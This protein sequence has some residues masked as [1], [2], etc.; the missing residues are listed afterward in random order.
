MD[1]RNIRQNVFRF[2]AQS[3]SSVK[4]DDCIALII[5]EILGY[6]NRKNADNY[7]PWADIC[8]SVKNYNALNKNGLVEKLK[9][10]ILK[11]FTLEKKYELLETKAIYSFNIDYI[12]F[13]EKFIEIAKDQTY[14]LR[15]NYGEKDYSTATLNITS[16]PSKTNIDAAKT[17]TKENY[18][19][20]NEEVKLN[21]LWKTLETEERKKL[22]PFWKWK[23][24]TAE[25]KSLEEY[26]IALIKRKGHKKVIVN[27]AI[28][29]ALFY[30]EWYKIKYTG[31]DSI[32]DTSFESISAQS[33]WKHLSADIRKKYLITINESKINE[34][35][36]WDDSLKLLGGL[37]LSYL[38]KGENNPSRVFARVFNN[39]RIEKEL[40]LNELDLNNQAMRQ[41]AQ[42]GG[43]IYEYIN[44]LINENYPFAE[45]DK[46]ESPFKEF[47]AFVGTG[48]K[49]FKEN[50]SKKFSIIWQVRQHTDFVNIY[51]AI[52]VKLKPEQGGEEHLFIH[53]ERLNE[54][55]IQ[56][57]LSSFEIVIRLKF[58]DTDELIEKGGF[59]F[60]RC[61]NGKFLCRSALKWQICDN[62]KNLE[63]I[64]FVLKSDEFEKAIQREKIPNYI[65]LWNSSYGEWTNRL[66]NGERSSVLFLNNNVSTKNVDQQLLLKS[67]EQDY[68]W[69]VVNRELEI[70]NNGKPH[71]LYQKNGTIEV[72]P[73]N[74]DLFKNTIRYN[75]DGLLSYLEGEITSLVY[76]VK[77]PVTFDVS[78]IDSNGSNKVLINSKDYSVH[79]KKRDM[80][81]FKHYSTG[82]SLMQGFVSFK[83][84]YKDIYKETIDCYLLELKADINRVLETKKISFQKIN[85][86]VLPKNEFVDDENHLENDTIKIK[87][88][89]ED[90]YLEIPIIRPLDRQNDIFQDRKYIN[91]SDIIPIKFAD[92]FVVRSI[93]S[94]GVTRKVLSNEIDKFQKLRVTYNNNHGKN[95]QTGI[96]G[97]PEWIKLTTYTKE[98][99][100]NGDFYF[101]TKGKNIS[102]E[103]FNGYKFCFLSLI[104]LKVEDLELVYLKK[105]SHNYVGFSISKKVDGIV[106][107]SFKDESI[108]YQETYRPVF[109]AADQSKI[110]IRTKQENRENRIK[111]YKQSFD[112][113]L[114]LNHFELAIVHN[115]Y[116]GMF[117]ILLA[118]EDQPQIL[119]KFHLEYYQHC[120]VQKQSVNYTALHRFAEEMLFDW[121][122]IPR[123]IWTEVIKNEEGK[124]DWVIN[125]FKNKKTSSGVEQYALSQCCEIY[126][127]SKL[128][129]TNQKNKI[130]MNIKRVKYINCF[131][132][133]KPEEKIK[134]LKKLDETERLY[135]DLL[136]ILKK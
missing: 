129:S 97:M 79:F 60:N 32:I 33:I 23:I 49:E 93:N 136:E 103:S 17:T 119:A 38:I 2:L 65:Q 66:I 7:K 15:T 115:L 70:L 90:N 82:T 62:P 120:T 110:N 30:S 81:G 96:K 88:G 74:K 43:S 132:I 114:A 51:P 78:Y 25:F 11:N 63:S 19:F 12:I 121:M 58:S 41:S 8:F 91:N 76:L 68:N 112:Y 34:S 98:I 105:E 71:K 54:W 75:E 123:K 77:E 72:Y 13:T 106:F 50:K 94:E 92:S 118:M 107:Q 6:I 3:N 89:T 109:V 59:Y 52:C 101:L 26:L 14:S 111:E 48:L 56:K 108:T 122:L 55:D 28:K 64:E 67:K 21:N 100:R 46:T 135:T 53:D 39:F 86:V 130:F 1:L 42:K 131:F 5:T 61:I 102:L 44:E 80:I 134:V 18:F 116:Y 126:W 124:K 40:D 69:A 127:N 9:V 24:S 35:V 73:Q 104:E 57:Q 133:Q 16:E 29:L 87:I 84:I 85:N 128:N 22:F 4:I 113:E 20:C 83:I 10:E 117:D 95:D 45:S 37:P 99:S 36:R 27:H 31:N 125:L 47:I